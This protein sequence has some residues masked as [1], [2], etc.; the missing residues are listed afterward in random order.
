L[1]KIGQFQD[2]LR[3]VF[4][5]VFRHPASVAPKMLEFYGMLAHFAGSIL[6][7]APQSRPKAPSGSIE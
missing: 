2:G 5:L 3:R 4:A 1:F 7:Q 6:K